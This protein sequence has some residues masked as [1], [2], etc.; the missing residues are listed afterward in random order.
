MVGG[1]QGAFIGVV[2]RMAATLDGHIELVCGA[3]SSTP[4]KSIASGKE[5][6]IPEDRC[7]GHYEEMFEKE[8]A[9]PPDQRMD[10][11]SIVTPNFMH[12][13]IAKMALEKGFNVMSDKPATFNLQEA[14]E[15]ETEAE[16]FPTNPPTRS[17]PKTLPEA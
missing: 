14:K 7:Y 17:F 6:Y 4:E 9:L 8:A 11:V 1:G 3:F 5:L 16:S 10:F 2:H 13:P 15:L 12:Y